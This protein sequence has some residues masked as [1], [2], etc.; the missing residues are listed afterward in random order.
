[1]DKAIV[2]F[3]S[4]GSPTRFLASNKV[5]LLSPEE[6]AQVMAL[7]HCVANRDQ[8]PAY[9]LLV[10]A[11]RRNAKN[12]A[13]W[14]DEAPADSTT[15]SLQIHHDGEPVADI[16]FFSDIPGAFLT[17]LWS[18]R[19][20]FHSGSHACDVVSQDILAGRGFAH[21]LRAGS[22]LD[23]TVSFY[24]CYFW[25]RV[26]AAVV[27][28]L[29]GYPIRIL[30][31]GHEVPRPDALDG[32]HVQ[33]AFGQYLLR[34]HVFRDVAPRIYLNGI[35]VHGH[36]VG[37]A[38]VAGD[39]RKAT[40]NVVHLD[41][42]QFHATLD[43]DRVVGESSMVAK[44]M[45]DLRRVYEERLCELKRTLSGV[46]FC[47]QGYQLARS[48]ER[49]FIFN[50]VPDVP[51]EWLGVVETLPNAVND[52]STL[53]T[54]LDVSQD[55]SLRSLDSVSREDVV[56][57][58]V[59]LARLTEFQ[60]WSG[61]EYNQM[62]WMLAYARKALCVM[63]LLHPDHWAH[64]LA[65]I[66]DD[67]FVAV[68]PQALGPYARL[69]GYT[70]GLPG[71]KVQLCES[72]VLRSGSVEAPVHDVFVVGVGDDSGFIVPRALNYCHAIAY[73]DTVWQF[74]RYEDGGAVLHR[75]A[76]DDARAINELAADLA[77][78][79]LQDAQ[80]QAAKSV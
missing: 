78:R 52:G 39:V 45:G 60:E 40:H 66:G 20:S 25:P 71:V 18:D 65:H 3:C 6:R 4:N 17:T 14:Y 80:E 75:K 73:A 56:V 5:V 10:D 26:K 30:V 12:V 51:A 79:K 28:N 62:A 44:V 58:R 59:T 8:A 16:R 15:P 29:A 34:E 63:Q 48:L 41:P 72:V 53:V 64:K 47:R 50:D 1:M 32:C 33:G 37:T 57:G 22:P 49:L 54:P 21:G 31:D 70:H 27:R 77:Q 46:D 61:G 38:P 24:T 36:D 13:I 42:K 67:T 7:F 43:G 35:C 9:A 68:V 69:D 74:T 19:W 2:G 23:K 55:D 76:E 11:L